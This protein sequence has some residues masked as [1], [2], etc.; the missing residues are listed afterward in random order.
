MS[1]IVETP[2]GSPY[3]QPVIALT[4]AFGGGL[5]TAARQLENEHGYRRIQ[6]SDEI[7]EEWHRRYG[8]EQ[9][10]VRSDLQRLGDEI[11][12]VEGNGALVDRA[13]SQTGTDLTERI[14]IES[15]KNVGEIHVLR[16]RF[17]YRLLVVAVLSEL[18]VRFRRSL[19]DYQQLGL[20]EA[21]LVEDDQRDRNEEVAYGQ[22]VEL[23]I[24][25]ADIIVTNNEEE[26]GEL[27][28]KMDDLVGLLEQ[29]KERSLTNVEIYMHAA[30]SIARSSKCLKRHVGVVLVDGRGQF[31]G[32]GY[33]ENP[34][35]TKPCVEEERYDFRCHR[36]IVRDRHF[37]LLARKGARCPVCATPI[38]PISGPPWRC[39]NC[40]NEGRKTNLELFYFPDRA[41]T[42]CTAVHAEVRAILAAGERA[43]GSTL[44]T[45]TFPCM[46]CAQ[47]I[48]EAGVA[49]IVYTEAYP[50]PYSAQRLEIAKV[51][52]RQF[53]GVRSSAVERLFPNPWLPKPT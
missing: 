45:T 16:R 36:D 24:D 42:W 53:E 5:T 11:R 46:Q 30:Y 23:C 28:Q 27:G 26:P 38:T 48:A 32:A 14:A 4:G 47:K 51:E 12:Q 9:E 50:D 3:P 39:P 17:G 19:T 43:R 35:G 25:L 40:L 10:P 21:H 52:V 33:N 49:R 8:G 1:R 2:K 41:M 18:G 29:T 20:D 44:Y 6:I 34:T 37:A 31:V 13:L 15:I 22:Q 7:R